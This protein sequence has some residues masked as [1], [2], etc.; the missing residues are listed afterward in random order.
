M[1]FK[2]IELKDLKVAPSE[3]FGTK[4]ALIGAGDESKHNIMTA[5]WG[6]LGKLWRKDVALAFIRPQRYTYQLVEDND[7]FTLS[8]FV[9]NYREALNICGSKSGRD[10]DKFEMAGLTPYSVEGTTAV[11]EANIVLVCKKM[12]ITDFDP[13][14]FVDE[15]LDET[16]Y[17][18]KDYHRAYVGEVVKVLVQE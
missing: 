8:F 10:G 9:E 12:A 16:F 15:T 5:S 1:G 14:G 18:A 11:K 6:M 7:M 2:E 13:S 4:W 17:S 3:L